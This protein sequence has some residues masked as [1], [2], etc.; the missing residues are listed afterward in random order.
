LGWLVTPWTLVYGTGGVAFGNVSGSFGYTAHDLFGF[1]SSA[2][3]GGSWS[4]T[5]TGA[6]GGG[7]VETIIAPNLTLRLEYR[8]TDLGTFSENVGLH[9]VCPI[10]A[11]ASPSNNAQINLHP[12]FQ[13]ITVGI[14]YN[15]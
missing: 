4:T 12:T 10:V 3:G 11:C 9:T 15:F 5:R 2:N 14:G 1:G 8:Y 7:G 13:N 6:T